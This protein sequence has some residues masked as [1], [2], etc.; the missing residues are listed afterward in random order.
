MGWWFKIPLWARILLAMA[1]GVALGFAL[2]PES[3]VH[4]GLDPTATA[5]ALKLVGDAFVRLIRMLAVPLI[6][7]SVTASVVSIGDLGKLGKSGAKV[8]ALYIPSGVLAAVVGIALGVLLQPGVG[9][10]VVASAT[11]PT[12]ADPPTLRQ[13]VEQI[14]PANPV[15]ALANGDMLSVILFALL[16]GVGLL[17]AGQASD[18]AAKAIDGAAH[19][20]IKLTG[21]IMELAPLGAFA[22]MTWVVAQMGSDALIRLAA[23]IGCVYLGCALYAVVVYGG[24]LRFGVNLPVVPFYRGML[25]PM[26]VAYATSSSNATLPVTLRA[27]I[28]KLGI[29][30]R[31]SAFVSSLGATVNMDGTAMYLALLTVFGAQMFGV[32]LGMPEYVAIAIAAS[33]GAVGAAGIPGGSIIFMPVVF[34]AV[35]VPLEVIAIVLG[36]DR[37]MDMARTVLNVI[38]DSVAA[39]AVA[40]WE[41]ELDM[42]AYRANKRE[43]EA[44]A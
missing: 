12:P 18:A 11:P 27:M 39:V 40:K 41:G 10:E 13:I 17:G 36:V 23:L 20:F 25:E 35:G 6:F 4:L 1:L 22:L 32:E 38:G 19:A 5:D 31:M 8:A 29:S 34:G 15:Q 37:L 9:P 26:A 21:Y 2:R 44:L 43:N 3:G 30:Q 14:I 16:F 7:V 28:E 42:A 33:L 24:F